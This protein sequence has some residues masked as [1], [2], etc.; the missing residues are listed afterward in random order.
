ML[1]LRRMA[2]LSLILGLFLMA[3]CGDDSNGKSGEDSSVKGLKAP[4]KVSAIETK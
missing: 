1:I 4:N 3:G 2:H